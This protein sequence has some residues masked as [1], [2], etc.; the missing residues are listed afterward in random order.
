MLPVSQLYDASI[1]F[2]APAAAEDDLTATLSSSIVEYG[3]CVSGSLL[4]P[5]QSGLAVTYL[6]SD[7]VIAISAGDEECRTIVVTTHHR[8]R[9]PC[10]SVISSVDFGRGLASLG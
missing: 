2:E 4:S 5:T 3:A 9:C 10:E 8:L 6:F 1:V 7:E